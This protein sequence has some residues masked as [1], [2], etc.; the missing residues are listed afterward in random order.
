MKNTLIQHLGIAAMSALI[1]GCCH[2]QTPAVAKVSDVTQPVVKWGAL[3]GGEHKVYTAHK[4]GKVEYRLSPAGDAHLY[5]LKNAAGM[6]AKISDYGATVISLTAPDRNGKFEDVVLGLETLEGYAG[7]NPPPY[8]GASIGRYGNRIGNA[9]FSLNG[10]SYQL[11]TNDHGNMLH[12]GYSG[13]DKVLW[14]AKPVDS[15]IGQALELTYTS[16]WGEEGFPG[17]LKVTVRYTL[18]K[19][20]ALRIDY[21]ATSDDDTVVNLT[22]HSYFNL[23]AKGDILGHQVYIKSDKITPVDKGLIPTGE[24]RPVA[25]TPFD[26]NKPTAIGARI[27]DKDAQLVLGPGYDHNWVITKPAGELGLMARVTEPVSGRIL[28]VSSTEPGLQFYSGNFLDGTII[29]KGG[30]A[31]KVHSGFCMEPQHFPDSPNK[32]NFPT[33]TLKKGETYKNTII[34]SFSAK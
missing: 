17:E 15:G 1:A 8:F 22:H 20:N 13:F 16:Q 2:A 3:K 27:N 19:D 29:G 33:T 7:T 18:T 11:S 26:F 6:T 5:T 12:G 14:Q 21:T 10:K 4:D 31:Y 28:E 25:G 32:P 30:V 23:A 34:Y 24:F 9:K